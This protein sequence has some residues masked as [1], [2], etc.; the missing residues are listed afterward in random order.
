M[1]SNMLNLY[2]WA[3]ESVTFIKV[4]SSDNVKNV[5]EEAVCWTIYEKFLKVGRRR[6]RHHCKALFSSEFS[7]YTVWMLSMLYSFK[8]LLETVWSYQNDRKILPCQRLFRQI[9]VIPSRITICKLWI[10]LLTETFYS[11]NPAL[12]PL[13]QRDLLLW[14]YAVHPSLQYPEE[15][16]M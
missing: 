16:I 9:R 6:C 13:L 4:L 1:F 12:N 14:N 2:I 11:Q 15:D 5:V 3:I 10:A 8:N 7:S